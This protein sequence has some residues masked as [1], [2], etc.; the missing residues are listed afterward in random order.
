MAVIP[1][2]TLRDASRAAATEVTKRYIIYYSPGGLSTGA[3]IG[4][5]I[6]I[7]VLLMFISMCCR[8]RVRRNRMLQSTRQTGPPP[9]S[10]Q[11]SWGPPPQ[12]G[13]QAWGPP[14][15]QP[16][17]QAWGSPPPLEGDHE[18]AMKY[19]APPSGPA[20]PAPAYTPAPNYTKA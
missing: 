2:P 15:P 17:Q 9:Q 18:A 3:I 10:G 6:G 16:G 20:P 11:Q 4:I 12:P 5:S 1:P 19:G 8:H 13:Q 14:P 7:A